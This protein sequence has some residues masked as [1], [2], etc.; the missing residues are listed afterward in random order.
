MKRKKMTMPLLIGGA[1]TSPIHTAVKIKPEFD[2]PVVH[3]RDASK[4]INVVSKL[5]SPSER[6]SYLDSVEME[7][8]KLRERHLKNRSQKKYIPLSRA[9]ANKL[10]TVWRKEVISEPKFIGT[11]VFDDYPL[12]DIRKYIDWTFF[13]HAWKLNGRYPEILEDPVKGVEAKK[14]LDEANRMLDEIVEKKWLK[15]KAVFG[16][17]PATST[18]DSLEIYDTQKNK[19]AD[20]HF[21]RNQ[22]EKEE[23]TPNLSL[24]DFV[25]P[26]ELGLTDYVGT[27]AVTAGEGIEEHLKRF[28]AQ[29]DDYSAIMLKVLADRLAEALAELLH[30]RVRKEFWGYA[31]DENLTVKEVIREKYRGIRPAPG[32]PA[33]PEHSEKATIFNLLNVEKNTGITLTE[34]YAMYPTAAVSGYYF[35]HPQAGYF[36]VGKILKDQVEDYANRKG[37]SAEEVEKLLTVNLVV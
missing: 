12:E 10:K 9:R 32:Y 26:K 21:L 8:Q 18:G 14:L 2:K 7:Y 22:E 25:A 13:F 17:F 30:Y 33:C 37:L 16:I 3:V 19:I 24:A 20:F 5:L 36:A 6:D 23:G 27:F 35:A 11:K 15:A 1:T 28:E 29:N 34:N 31:A 4:V